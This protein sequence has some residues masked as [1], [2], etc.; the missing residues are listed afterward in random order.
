M[1]VGWPHE[2][3]ARG[4]T[5][6]QAPHPSAR[7]WQVPEPPF[8]SP[9]VPGTAS[10]NVPGSHA[11]PQVFSGQQELG[12]AQRKNEAYGLS[13]VHRLWVSATH[14]PPGT[15]PQ[16]PP[17]QVLSQ[18]AAPQPAWAQAKGSAWEQRRPEPSHAAAHTASNKPHV[19]SQSEAAKHSSPPSGEEVGDEVAQ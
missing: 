12:A 17:P 18:A 13:T 1:A 4:A 3:A 15:R 5:N 10:Q 19:P 16:N 9:L 7:A 14:A 8:H 6:A 11:P 2:T